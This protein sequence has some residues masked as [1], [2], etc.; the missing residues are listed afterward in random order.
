M[1]K[2]API[3]IPARIRASLSNV[4][5]FR[6]HVDQSFSADFLMHEDTDH[7]LHVRFDRA[8]V[9]RLLDE[10]PLSTETD[11]PNYG[12]IRDH[13]AYLVEDSSF[14]RSQSDTLK[15]VHPSLRHY[16]FVTGW[17]C[18]DV[19][20]T[21]CPHP[22]LPSRSFHDRP[23]PLRQIRLSSR[24]LGPAESGQEP[25]GLLPRCTAAL[26]SFCRETRRTLQSQ[27]FL[28]FFLAIS[29]AFF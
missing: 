19:A 18:L 22:R 15:T 17:T 14:W 26:A 1:P 27:A 16:R 2:Y 21:C 11:T 9:V 29:G 7:M 8:E 3:E 28:P 20:S 24:R 6:W 25:L 13:L 12:L 23:R 5:E 4:L 10:M